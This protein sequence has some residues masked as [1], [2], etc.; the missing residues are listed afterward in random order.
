MKHSPIV[1]RL[2]LNRRQNLTFYHHFVFH[3]V[4]H[5]NS[6]LSIISSFTSVFKEISVS[7]VFSD[8][9]EIIVD[10]IIAALC[11]ESESM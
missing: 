2:C 11:R 3:I 5:V 1:F 7:T 8:T 9:F 10:K 6:S 4:P